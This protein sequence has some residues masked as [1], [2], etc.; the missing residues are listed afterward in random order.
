VTVSVQLLTNSAFGFPRGMARR[1][2]PVA[3]ACIH[4]TGNGRT[5]AMASAR[6]AAQLERNYANRANSH[7][8][9]AH[10]YVARDGW[11]I[12]AVDPARYAAWSNGDVNHPHLT[13]PGVARAVAFRSKGYN[14]NEAYW[15]EF[16]C[17]GF[18]TAHPI[19]TAQMEFVAERIAAL[20][21]ASGLPINRETV[22]GHWEI[23]GVD[24]QN[25]PCPPS[26]HESFLNLVIHRANAILHP[27]PTTHTLRIAHNAVVRTYSLG[28]NGCI[29]RPW[30]DEK[31]TGRA[32][33]AACA[34]PVNRRTCDGTSSATT[35]KVATGKYRGK[36]I[37]VGAGVSVTGGTA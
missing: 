6:E 23:N 1:V 13:N 15:L 4:I 33:T 28:A 17:I 24:R 19:T 37:R 35:T 29:A 22:H 9:S 26:Q 2:K 25:C 34:M 27:A 21:K 30:V 3:L 32:S 16:E 36:T 7:G 11:A 8:P 14:V 5:A 18:G 10:Y 31:W 12:E 20:A